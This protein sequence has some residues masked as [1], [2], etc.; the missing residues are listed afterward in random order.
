M[1]LANSTCDR[2]G[3]LATQLSCTIEDW[4]KVEPSWI[5]VGSPPPSV[6]MYCDDCRELVERE[7]VS[8]QD[9]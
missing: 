4:D 8:R 9:H 1:S 7:Y 5:K 6:P 2:C 3:K